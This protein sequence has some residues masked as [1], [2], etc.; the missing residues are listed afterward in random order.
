MTNDSMQK[1]V[2]ESSNVFRPCLGRLFLT[3][4]EKTKRMQFIKTFFALSRN[5]ILHR[6]SRRTVRH[7]WTLEKQIEE[8]RDGNSDRYSDQQH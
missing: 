4:C 6:W 5:T 8:V 7:K 1:S 2:L 3:R